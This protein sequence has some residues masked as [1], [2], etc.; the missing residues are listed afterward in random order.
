[1]KKVLH[2]THTDISFDNRILKEIEAILYT[3]NYEVFAIGVSSDE[4][5]A[6][7]DTS[8][9]RN[10]ILTLELK[11]K[12]FKFLPKSLLYIFNFI[13]LFF[14]IFSYAKKMQPEVVHCHDTLVLPIGLIYKIFNRKSILIYDAH[15]LES[16]KNGQGSF[17]SITTFL[18]EKIS[19]K[20]I[21]QL[22][23]VSPSI[24]N[25]Y[26]NS[27]GYKPVEIILNSP[28]IK[29][30]E[31]SVEKLRK[32]NTDSRYFHNK[33]GFT[34]QTKVF[35]YL[36][37]LVKGRFI[38]ELLEVFSKS[39]KNSAIVFVGYGELKAKVQDYSNLYPN[40]RLHAPVP[41]DRVVET[42]LSADVGLCLIEDISLSDYYCLPNKLFEY[43]FAGKT[44][45]ASNL[46]DISM[47][48]N[49]YNLGFC[50]N[51]D[52]NSIK[53]AIEKIEYSTFNTN[54]NDLTE[55]SW[56]FQAYKLISL[57]DKL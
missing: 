35:V 53:Q 12:K 31:N 47:V 56:E 55:L 42:I 30:I 16:N 52:L 15:E 2:L 46:P 13:E 22:I 14:K 27:F 33:Y 26:Q 50:C 39:V 8:I 18:I 5:A 44:I 21:D 11:T 9:F 4:G 6:I 49:K 17:I 23:T 51:M 29:G 38:E 25:W 40:I 45:L 57:Y 19:W 3:K 10:R 32:S 34:N 20:W 36:G 24:G 1:M 37:A 7:N 41:H 54:N 48:V 43:C 28:K